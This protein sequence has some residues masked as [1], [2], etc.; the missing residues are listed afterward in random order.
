[1][2]IAPPAVPR[3]AKDDPGPRRI[4]TCSVKKFSRTLTPGIA[5][6]VDED[7]V[8]G[9]EAAN[10]EAVAESVAALAGPECHAGRVQ[11]ACFRL[12][13]FLSASTSLLSTVTRLRRVQQ[14]LGKLARRLQVIDLVRRRRIRIGVAVGR[15]GRRH[16][17]TAPARPA[18]AGYGAPRG[19]GRC[20]RGPDRRWLRR[21]GLRARHRGIDRHRREVGL[22]RFGAGEG[23]HRDQSGNR[24]NLAAGIVFQFF[25]D[26][27]S[28]ALER[29]DLGVFALFIRLPQKTKLHLLMRRIA[30]RTIVQALVIER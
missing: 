13:A 6:A 2:L 5:H 14:R 10:E 19:A 16:W 8:A 1:M 9:I 17:E 28:A 29:N 23:G 12:V 30:R 27:L 26:R 15:S 7:V 11:D 20:G 21:R 18:P 3:P 22:L 24:R 4:S 25:A